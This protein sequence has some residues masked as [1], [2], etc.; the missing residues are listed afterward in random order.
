MATLTKLSL[1]VSEALVDMQKDAY[2][3]PLFVNKIFDWEPH[4]QLTETIVNKKQ[5][6]LQLLFGHSWTQA[7]I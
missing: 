2:A 5:H 3:P 1:S 4:R 6:L 7:I